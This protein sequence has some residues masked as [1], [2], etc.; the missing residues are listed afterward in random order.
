M[1]RNCYDEGMVAEFREGVKKYIVPIA[2]RLKAEQAKR[3]GVP[4]LKAYDDTFKFPDG[5]PTPKGTKDDIFSNGRKM[6]HEL[7]AETGEFMDLMLDNELIDA[8]TRPGK[9]V[10]GYC[11]NLDLFKSPFIFANFNGTAGDIDVL[12]HEAG[13]AF[14]DYASRDIFPSNL[15]EYSNET[16]ETHSMSM[17]FFT[18]PWMESFFGPDTNKYKYLHLSSAL[19]FIPY[20]TMVDEFQHH[21]YARPEMTPAQRNELWLSLESQ[22]RPYLDYGGI[23]FYSEGRRWQAQHHIYSSPFYYIDY[24]LAQAMALSFWAENQ[25]DH[26]SAWAKYRRFVGFAGTKTFASLIEDAGLSS[27]FEPGTLYAVANAAT[28]WLDANGKF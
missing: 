2:D 27:P 5:N 10:G 20:G 12:T 16:A 6:Y 21:V 23:P 3:I 18:W 25:K 1:Q 15:K 24:C 14:A 19:T 7:S 8:E 26:D 13:H 22:Y 17:E 11:A 9:S 28:A 4:T